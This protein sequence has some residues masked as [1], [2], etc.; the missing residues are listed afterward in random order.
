MTTTS[1]LQANY[2]KGYIDERTLAR[3]DIDI[4][5]KAGREIKNF[6]VVPQGGLQK[7]FGTDYITEIVGEG[8]T[9]WNEIFLAT[10]EYQ[11]ESDYLL[12]FTN[13]NLS[14]YY[15]GTH[16]ASVISPYLT[17]ELQDIRYSQT[18][19]NLIVAHKNHQP[20]RLQRISAHAGWSFQPLNFVYYPTYDFEKD[21]FNAVF[22]PSA[23]SGAVNLTSSIGV[24]KASHVGGLFFGNEGTIRITG[25][26]SPTTVSGFTVND[27]A[28]TNPISGSLCDLFE[29][30]WSDALGW[31]RCVTFFQNRLVFGG[32]R[33]LSNG[34]W[35]SKSNQYNN[36]DDSELLADN[37]ISFYITTDDANV[38]ENIISY[39]TLIIFTNKRMVALPFR[40]DGVFTPTNVSYNTESADA[41]GNLKPLLFDNSI[42]FVDRGG[43][44]VWSAQYNI[45]VSGFQTDDISILS[46][47]LIR[48]PID[49]AVIR[50]PTTDQGNYFILVNSD[51]TLAIM[52]SMGSQEVLAWTL[53]ETDGYFRSIATSGNTGYI[54]VERII[55]GIKKFYIERLNFSGFMDCQKVQTFET[56]QTVIE[57]L[58]Y[59]EGKTVQVIADGYIEVDKVVTDGKITLTNAA[60]NVTVGIGIDCKL[61]PLPVFIEGQS[62]IDLYRPKRIKKLY[63][64]YYKSLALKVDGEYVQTLQWDVTQLNAQP[65]LKSGVAE[66]TLFK[67]YDIR[68]KIEITHNYPCNA[69]IRAVGLEVDS[70]VV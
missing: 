33:S 14:I 70:E 27:F 51:G 47:H 23:T 50:N 3:I 36:F 7:R 38:I 15:E 19:D 46:Q 54:V 58:E 32:S 48:S 69:F 28:N 64:D 37:A 57:N 5:K 68:D 10:F 20:Y 56:P 1:H 9:S 6:V 41:I 18:I 17:D 24:F 4:Y 16:V 2:T 13:G 12:V 61:V 11:D 49:N 42:I 8:L 26:G 31:P 45:Q 53:S 65:E 29:P 22:T 40:T 66:F 35:E 25:F 55:N 52:Q 67:G 39:K 34:V 60:S 62:G 44:I 21:Y 43:K 63:L 59:L 30:A